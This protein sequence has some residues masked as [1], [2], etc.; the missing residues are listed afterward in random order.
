MLVTLVEC[1]I[2]DSQ[3]TRAGCVRMWKRANQDGEVGGS[4]NYCKGCR[5]GEERETGEGQSEG[6]EIILPEETKRCIGPFGCGK[7]LPLSAYYYSA[8]R[9][10]VGKNPYSTY[11]K[12]CEKKRNRESR[13]EKKKHDN[14]FKK[15]KTV[16]TAQKN[17]SEMTAEEKIQL[18]EEMSI[19]IKEHTITLVFE[20][21]DEKLYE[22]VCSL[23]K[24]DRR[25]P[26]QHIMWMLEQIMGGAVLG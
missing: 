24:K 18:I 12:E 11:C 15:E 10:K 21:E 5:M 14:G 8:S 7:E 26:S 6:I 25:I 9:I 2:N 3:I 19:P 23:A 16:A 22:Y 4:L 1:K 20:E 17:G 13:E